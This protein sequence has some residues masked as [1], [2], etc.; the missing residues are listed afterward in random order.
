M[1]FPRVLQDDE[2][3]TAL[4]WDET[5]TPKDDFNGF[6]LQNIENIILTS[7]FWV[8]TFFVLVFMST[9]IIIAMQDDGSSEVEDGDETSDLVD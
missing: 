5:L 2:T 1:N 8:G 9:E 4:E 6:L 3:D 7:I